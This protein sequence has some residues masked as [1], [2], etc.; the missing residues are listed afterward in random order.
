M[1]LE[2]T[3]QLDERLAIVQQMLEVHTNKSVAA[4]W[5]EV[6]WSWLSTKA[7]ILEAA[8]KLVPETWEVCVEAVGRVRASS[9]PPQW[10]RVK[11]LVERLFRIG[12]S[13][14]DQSGTLFR[15]YRRN[16]VSIFEMYFA[17]DAR[18]WLPL[19]PAMC[20]ERE[21]RGLCLDVLYR[22]VDLDLVG[23]DGNESVWGR[24][25]VEV[26]WCMI[27]EDR[28]DRTKLKTAVSH[29]VLFAERLK[30]GNERRYMVRSFERFVECIRE[31]DIDLLQPAFVSMAK[32]VE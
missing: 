5:D 7:D 28:E 19:L 25:A 29:I 10:S 4:D 21:V 8:G 16:V 17:E 14:Y 15:D 2:A 30:G 20:P 12:N 13:M 26:F 3:L 1:L 31:Q 11:P 18:C 6:V 23:G 32:I 9:L 24:L 27:W 22:Y